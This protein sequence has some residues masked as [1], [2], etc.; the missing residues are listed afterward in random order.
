MCHATTNRIAA[1]AASG[2]LEASGARNSSTA[3]SVTVCTMPASGLVA[4]LRMFVAVRAMAP[5]AAKPPNSGTTM[6]AIPWPM[7]S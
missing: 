3:T 7:S 1:N 5:V 6:F 2:M 4:P